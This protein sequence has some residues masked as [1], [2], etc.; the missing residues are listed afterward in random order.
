MALTLD[1]KAKGTSN[2]GTTTGPSATLTTT[3]TNDVIIAF[4]WARSSN[5]SLPTATISG[6]SLSWTRRFRHAVTMD[7][8]D[9]TV[10]E[11]WYAIAASALSSAVISS[12]FDVNVGRCNIQVFG[13]NGAYTA[14]P[15]DGNGS[16]PAILEGTSASNTG[17]HAVTYSTTQT[18][19]FVMGCL[20][21]DGTTLVDGSPADSFT[22]IDST[23]NFTTGSCVEYKVFSTTQT[24]QSHAVDDSETTNSFIAV[25]DALTSNAVTFTGTITDALPG[26]LSFY[27]RLTADITYITADSTAYTADQIK[28]PGMKGKV[29]NPDMYGPIDQNFNQTFTL[30][31][32]GTVANANIGDITSTFNNPYSQILNGLT[33]Q[34][35]TIAGTSNFGFSYSQVLSGAGI[36][37]AFIA[38]NLPSAFTQLL[39]GS[40]VFSGPIVSSFANPYRQVLFG[41]QLNTAGN[42]AYYSWW[43]LGP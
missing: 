9:A 31:L 13:V 36:I 15:F 29:R 27:R 39:N 26:T 28:A 38:M 6:G 5:S 16:L 18:D 2:T 41:N 22:N 35:I 40:E 8:A 20:V 34:N 32:A 3:L 12:T 14:S 43:F 11:E 21:S 1:G 17:T 4:V 7:N 23:Q 33:Y 24:S 10:L 42:T 19:T 37:S 30:T 25:I